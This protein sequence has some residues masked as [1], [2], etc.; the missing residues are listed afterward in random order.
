MFATHIK[1]WGFVNYYHTKCLP[2]YTYT[3][4]STKHKL[5][6][7]NVNITYQSQN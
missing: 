5:I 1:S 3:H 2:L 6:L 7:V 4:S